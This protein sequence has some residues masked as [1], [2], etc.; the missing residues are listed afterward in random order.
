MWFFG[1]VLLTLVVGALVHT[2]VDR[3]EN[4]RTRDRVV[5]LWLLWFVAGAGVWGII[6]GIAHLGPTSDQLA[7]SIG[8]RQ[9]FFQWE[10]GW[11]DIAVGVLGVG[12][13]WRRDSWLTAAVVAFAILYWGDALGHV[14]QW[15][16]HGNTAPS[17]VGAIPSD[18][19]QPLVAVLLL[20]AYRRTAAGRREDGTPTRR[21]VAS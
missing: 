21:P 1:F 6:E 10:V 3:G 18:V 16:A 15:V 2:F 13:I 4:R 19:L 5:E 14:M 7:E 12:S 11:A 20:V 17:N 9:S 8:Y